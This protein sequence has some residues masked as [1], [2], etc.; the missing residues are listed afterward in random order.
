MGYVGYVVYVCYIVSIIK[1]GNNMPKFLSEDE[2][3]DNDKILL[4]FNE[5]EQHVQQGIGQMTKFNTLGFAGVLDAPDG[6]YIPENKNAVAIQST[7]HWKTANRR[8]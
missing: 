2:V 1:C 4:G 7:N 3:R 8:I 5:K 6:W